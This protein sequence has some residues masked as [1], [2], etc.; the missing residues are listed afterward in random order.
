M[1]TSLS[2]FWQPTVLRDPILFSLRLSP[3]DSEWLLGG[4]A[5]VYLIFFY[6]VITSLKRTPAHQETP[7]RE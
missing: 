7:K 1:L 3:S 6:K 5:N 2:Y 4:I